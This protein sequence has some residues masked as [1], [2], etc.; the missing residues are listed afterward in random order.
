MA[1]SDPG[2]AAEQHF[3]MYG[4]SCRTSGLLPHL[5]LGEIGWTAPEVRAR[6]VQKTPLFLSFVELQYWQPTDSISPYL[7]YSEQRKTENVS[8]LQ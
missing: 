6:F 2:C 4:I 8:I 1:K 3:Q 7:Q 5:D